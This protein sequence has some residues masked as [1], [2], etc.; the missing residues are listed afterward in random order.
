MNASP[1][2]PA[3]AQHTLEKTYWGHVGGKAI[4]LYKLSLAGGLQLHVTNYGAI[5]QSLYVPRPDG[6]S[7]DVVLG[8]DTLHEYI[9]DPFYMGC[10]VGRVANRID[11]GKVNIQGRT[12][13]LAV[14]P[15]GFHHHGG[16][17][18]FGKKVWDAETFGT[19]NTVG[20]TLQYVSAHL[21]EGF[22]GNLTTQ[23]TYTLHRDN[24][25]T[26]EFMA[27]TDQPTLVNLTQH[28]YFNLGGHAHGNIGGHLLQTHAPWYL[29]ATAR[30]MPTGEIASVRGTPFDFREERF[31][32][33]QIDSDYS[34]LRAAGG[35]DHF[36]VLEREHS[37]K[38]KAAASVI[39]PRSRLRMDVKTTEPGFH[40]YA[41][42]FLDADFRG[43][44]GARYHF[45]GGLCLETHHFPDA[46]N[47]GNFPSTVLMPGVEFGSLS[48][49]LFREG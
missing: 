40:F 37:K 8:Y 15:G 26:V 48:E 1:A 43:K 22:P 19:A 42:N 18:G 2:Q 32:D 34:Q 10:V 13:Q 28:S 47:H 5:I 12:Y 11:T 7:V 30:L 20:I 21:E 45:R 36:F 6:T 31:I 46:V 29:P 27:T 24:R 35:Y 17:I 44:H 23:V 39:E 9:D 14:T 41:G 38:L 33:E 4:W 16:H 25:L 49:F 3:A